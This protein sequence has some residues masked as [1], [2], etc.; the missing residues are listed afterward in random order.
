MLQLHQKILV[1]IRQLLTQPLGLL[2]ELQHLTRL[3]QLVKTH[4]L[5]IL[6][7]GQLVK[8][9]LLIQVLIQ[10]LIIQQFGLQILQ[11]KLVSQQTQQQNIPLLI[12][13]VR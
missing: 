1:K 9:Q 12:T 6:Q 7:L 13:L 3:Q 10:L 5:H 2:I 8:I 4:P 11:Y